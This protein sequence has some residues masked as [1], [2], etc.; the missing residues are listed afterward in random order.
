MIEYNFDIKGSVFHWKNLHE[1]GVW[2]CVL[3]SNGRY[4][5]TA[6]GDG[7]LLQTDTESRNLVKNYGVV[8]N[9]IVFRLCL[10]D[11]RFFLGKL[12]FFFGFL[13]VF[14][15]GYLGFSVVRIIC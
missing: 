1:N 15:R 12:F 10:T 5:F 6:G 14:V 4:V 11:I 2:C 13:S 9:D 3:S 8:S 7:V